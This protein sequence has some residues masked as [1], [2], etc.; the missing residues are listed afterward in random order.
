MAVTSNST[1][2]RFGIAPRLQVV[3][4]SLD[5]CKGYV[6]ASGSVLIGKCRHNRKPHWGKLNETHCPD[7]PF[8]RF[9]LVPVTGGVRFGHEL[10]PIRVEAY[11]ATS[12][13]IELIPKN[14]RMEKV[15]RVK[16]GTFPV[17][18]GGYK[19]LGRR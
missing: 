7:C 11:R 9:T 17:P 10:R 6:E 12:A 3:V 16:P 1:D 18:V 14:R 13:P 2:W 15:A 19:I 4:A 8:S 5:G